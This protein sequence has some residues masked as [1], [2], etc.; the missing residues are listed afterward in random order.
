M[1]IGRSGRIAATITLVSAVAFALG[2]CTRETLV[3]PSEERI[4]GEW[5]SISSF[6]GR[7]ATLGVEGD[8]SFA[9]ADLPA[10]VFC[11]YAEKH[12]ADL[13]KGGT[14]QVEGSWS[15]TDTDDYRI[16]RFKG[17]E[18]STM[19][20]AMSS[21]GEIRLRVLN[22]STID[23]AQDVDFRRAGG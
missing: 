1:R 12:P 15:L 17:P 14:E 3:D 18:C 6:D 16:L 2:G 7:T 19:V 10:G 22:G 21:G 9:I 8:G 20:L 4:V 13:A 23:D 11:S 5:E